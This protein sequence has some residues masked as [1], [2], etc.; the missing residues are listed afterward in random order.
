[1]TDTTADP[2]V[3]EADQFYAHPPE[4]VWRAL[5]TPELMARWLMQPSGFAPVVGTRF[6]FRGQPMPSVGFSGDIAC[7]VIAVQEG[8]QLTISWADAASGQPATWMVSWT[9]YP[10]GH[11]TRVILR[12][13]GFDLDD[14]VQ[15]RSRDI[16]GKGWV[17]IAAQLGKLLDGG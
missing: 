17:R 1:M 16:M 8:K 14:V 4:R 11:G 5:T 15:R 12:H 6:T 3:I 9:L 2:Q 10:E 7:E 13:T